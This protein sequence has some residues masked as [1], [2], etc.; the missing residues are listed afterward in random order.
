[1]GV[2]IVTDTGCDLPRKLER[3]FNIEAVPFFFHFGLEAWRDKTMP[4]R[5][6]LAK[7]REI[8]PKTAAPS[9]EEFAD[10]FR[11]GIEAG[12]QVL[13]IPI[14]SKHSGTYAAAVAAS[15]QFS[16]RDIAIVDS[17][18]LSIGQGLLALAAA[19][20]A[21]EKQKLADIVE[22]VKDVRERLH[23]F[24]TLN[25]IEYLIRGGRA[26]RLSGLLAGLL[27]I[28]PILTL[29]EGELTLI[30]R[31]RGRQASKCKLI[32]LAE[33][34]LPAETLA[35]GHVA[36][37]TEARTLVADLA[38]QTGFPEEKILLVETGMALATHGGPGTLGIAVVSR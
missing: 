11:R 7:A 35:V 3:Q 20:A 10:I 9:T 14:T 28:R 16:P 17:Q 36:C 23:V 34:F 15:R 31:P 33:Q 29:Q 13:C 27:K 19:R 21:Q 8:W 22:L 30:K 12:D 37:E 2:R 25:T 6:F 18:S 1:M 26:S 32:N 4:M 5:D 24:I 38:A